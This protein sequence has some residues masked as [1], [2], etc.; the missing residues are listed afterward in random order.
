M[1][2]CYHLMKRY[3]K[4]ILCT[5]QVLCILKVRWNIPTD[6]VQNFAASGLCMVLVK[7]QRQILRL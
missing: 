2:F 3:V 6:A 1:V 7:L 4:I 5:W